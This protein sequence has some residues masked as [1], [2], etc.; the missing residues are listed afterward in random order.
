M[1]KEFPTT[2][3]RRSFFHSG[4]DEHI[5]DEIQKASK[6]VVMNEKPKNDDLKRLK[7]L[8]KKRTEDKPKRNAK[9]LEAYRQGVSQHKVAAFLQLSQPTVSAI[10]K[11]EKMK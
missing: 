11:R 4:I 10:I 5:L 8:Y 6:L 7:K 1:L 9:I 3:E 2:E